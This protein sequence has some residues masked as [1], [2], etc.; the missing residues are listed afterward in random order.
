[1]SL[2]RASADGDL[3]AVK[4]LVAEGVDINAADARGRT[5]LLEAAWGGYRDI[6]SLLLEKGAV[7]NRPDSSGFTPICR[8][9]EEGFDAITALLLEN[10]AE[11]NIRA[12]TRGSTPLMLAAENGNRR[13]VAMLLNHGAQVTML[14]QF[15]ESALDR[16]LRYDHE[17]AAA[18]LREQGAKARPERSIYGSG[19]SDLRPY[20]R[21][22]VP[23]WTSIGE[24]TGFDDLDDFSDDQFEEEPE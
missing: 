3:A 2:I 9:V 20:K 21:A 10:G 19:D 7:V 17:E 18:L 1:M 22:A 24:E 14:D 16:A 8:S 4:R 23:Q 6:V 13:I 11:V 5:A 12:G 15:G